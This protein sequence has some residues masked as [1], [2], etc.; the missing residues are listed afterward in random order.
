[1]RLTST[2]LWKVWSVERYVIRIW[3]WIWILRINVFSK[4][5][6]IYITP[7]PT[8]MT[9]SIERSSSSAWVESWLAVSCNAVVDM[10]Y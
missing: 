4:G 8:Y 9:P 3:I 1:M 7:G 5:H 10:A 6:Q 2:F